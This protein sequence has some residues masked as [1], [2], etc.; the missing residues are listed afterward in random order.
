MRL[1]L[2]GKHGG[3]YL[4]VSS[5]SIE[6]NVIDWILNIAQYPIE[7]VSNRYGEL[8]KVLMSHW[9]RYFD[10][11]NESFDRIANTNRQMLNDY[12]NHMVIA[13]PNQELVWDWFE[14]FGRFLSTPYREN[15]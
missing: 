13:E 7:A 4:D 9:P 15:E 1:A 14:E 12:E 5:F 2:I 6:D 10:S 11:F 3:I 8:P